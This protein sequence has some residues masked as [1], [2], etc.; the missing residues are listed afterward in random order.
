[1]KNLFKY[2]AILLF[3][4]VGL[5]SC[6]PAD[7]DQL[8]P[9]NVLGIS[10][11]EANTLLQGVWY[12]DRTEEYT[13]LCA[14]G[15]LELSAVNVNNL[16]YSNYKFEFSNSASS[17]SYSYTGEYPSVNTV[18]LGYGGGGD[19]T[20]EFA[21]YIAESVE[22]GYNNPFSPIDEGSLGLALF[23]E[24]PL[25]ASLPLFLCWGGEI[26][27]IDSDSFTI[28]I[29]WNNKVYRAVFKRD[30]NSSIP[31]NQSNIE[32][33]YILES[34]KSVSGGVEQSEDIYGSDYQLT[35]TT[36][37]NY[38][39]NPQSPYYSGTT[40]SQVDW[41]YVMPIVSGGIVGLIWSSTEHYVM[42]NNN[43]F[44]IHT[45]DGQNLVLRDYSSCNTFTEYSFTKL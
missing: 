12:I 8:G 13:V 27:E 41:G 16:N 43:S 7:E 34:R 42:I 32:G 11:E 21:T 33:T 29:T 37:L 35:L 20:F 36:N 25:L 14:N 17:G 4:I 6:N 5:S 26:V 10:I 40:S 45:Q 15:Q 22:V 24:D 39:Y 23:G 1:M 9:T 31:Y 44:R 28:Q 18:N 30:V 19:Y 3:A 38:S 2:L